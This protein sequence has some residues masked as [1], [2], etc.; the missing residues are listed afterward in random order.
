MT[1]PGSRNGTAIALALLLAL[2]TTGIYTAPQ[3]RGWV[4][5]RGLDLPVPVGPDLYF[6]LNLSALEQEQ[7]TLVNPWYSS[8]MHS[9]DA[10][11]TQFGLAFRGFSILWHF[12]GERWVV[13][14]GVWTAI[15]TG[16]TF[17]SVMILLRELCPDRHPAWWA[18]GA[19]FVCLVDLSA[20]REILSA[21]F[22][23]PSFR[24]FESL[25]LPFY[26]PFFP[27]VAVPLLFTYL[28]LQINALATPQRWF[29]WLAMAV[30]QGLALAAFPYL[31]MLLAMI[32]GLTLGVLLLQ[33]S[34]R[35]YW[36]A[37]AG[38]ACAS[39]F[40]DGA[41]FL[42][43]RSSSPWLEWGGVSPL[44]F[45]PAGWV[46]AVGGV[47]ILLLLL[48]ALVFAVKGQTRPEVRGTLLAFGLGTE[49]LLFSDH[50]ISPL[51][52]V[53]VHIGYF[54]SATLGT[55]GFY[56]LTRFTPLA[57]PR[58]VRIAVGVAILMLLAHGA[59]VAY[60]NILDTD[61]RYS[62]VLAQARLLTSVQPTAKDLVILPARFVNQGT[63]VPLICPAQVLFVRIGERLLAPDAAA[64][65]RQR[66]ALYLYVSGWS[67]ERVET[68]L[69]RPEMATISDWNLV[70]RIEEERLR[71][72]DSARLNVSIRTEL[73][74]FMRAFES[75]E[76]SA[77]ETFL[78]PY[79][80]VLVID[81]V[82]APVFDHRRL[83]R[84]MEF[85]EEQQ[86][87]SWVLNIGVPRPGQH[88]SIRRPAGT[89]PRPVEGR[90]SGLSGQQR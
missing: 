85:G 2:L 19:I 82:I 5:G 21:W 35:I 58:W 50:F 78:E 24:G 3:A 42:F 59:L 74:P 29:F 71:L 10:P 70:M 49:L 17:L 44:H 45:S 60:G 87:G 64:I 47:T 37:I 26:R 34:T 33:G 32:T 23:M 55:L 25:H 22:G 18:L 6:Y 16:L 84:F 40:L 69:A 75:T 83:G 4:E 12:L 15:F 88:D 38:F 7:E 11:H 65:H 61:S 39:A 63:W 46:D 13:A 9:G 76:S 56:L 53:S 79:E 48:S 86:G 51:L 43:T 1:S 81:S 80:R 62:E 77:G 57:G 30:V 14:L 54:A 20:G 90:V 67:S 89:S 36:P 73:L 27:Q 31:T 52:Q 41:F 28:A 8:R 72:L 66:Q 68:M